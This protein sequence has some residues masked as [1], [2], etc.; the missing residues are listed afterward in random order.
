MPNTNQ[1]D[2]DWYSCTSDD[3]Y[4]EFF[5]KKDSFRVATTSGIQTSWTHY[6]IE[7]DTMYFIRPGGFND[8]T[9]VIIDYNVGKSL[10]MDFL[11]DFETI[12]FKPLFF[13]TENSKKDHYSFI[14]ISE[15]SKNANCDKEIET[16]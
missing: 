3:G 1:L 11:D 8:S 16:K 4:L 2:G 14:E 10:T 13:N 9:K 7:L 6:R 5:T 12:E 15:R